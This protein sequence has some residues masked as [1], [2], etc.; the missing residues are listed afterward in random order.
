[1]VTCLMLLDSRTR[2]QM[3]TRLPSVGPEDGE[4]MPNHPTLGKKQKKV[5]QK[6]D[7]G[8]GFGIQSKGMRVSIVAQQK[9]TQL[10]STRMQVR[11]LTSLS[12]S[13]IRS[14]RGVGCR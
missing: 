14:C 9:Q 12:G 10:V 6:E 4:K 7:G 3:G 13:R 11:S 1:M 8:G 2:H 5:E